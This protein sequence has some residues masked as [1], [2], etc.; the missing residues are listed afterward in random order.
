MACCDTPPEDIEA[1]FN[2]F[3]Q[4]FVLVSPETGT[5]LSLPPSY[6][7]KVNHDRLDN[8]DEEAYEQLRDFYVKYRKWLDAFDQASL[9]KSQRVASKVLKWYLDDAITA[10]EYRYHRY[11]VNPILGFH[12]SLTSLMTQHHRIDDIKDAKAYIARLR[13]YD[14]MMAQLIEQIEI[15]EKKGIIDIELIGLIGFIEFVGLIGLIGFIG[16]IEFVG[17]VGIIFST[18]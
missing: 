13:Q 2:E 17:F 10:H 6:G 11:I 18:Q 1:L 3:V 5:Q 15:R 4:D 9:T 8:V 7:I 12:N 16:F 14:T